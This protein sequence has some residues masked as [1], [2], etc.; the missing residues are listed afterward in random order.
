MTRRPLTQR[1]QS[2]WVGNSAEVTDYD[3][4]YMGSRSTLSS[5]AHVLFKIGISG[6]FIK[7]ACC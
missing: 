1:V 4:A 7:F 2:S 3:M 6:L 5:I